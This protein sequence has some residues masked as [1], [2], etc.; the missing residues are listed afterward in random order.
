MPIFKIQILEHISRDLVFAVENPIKNVV[1]H[2][3]HDRLERRLGSLVVGFSDPGL[4]AVARLLGVAQ[5]H[6]RVGL[7]ENRVV[8]GGIAH[9]QGALHHDHLQG[10]GRG[11]TRYWNWVT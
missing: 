8:H 11:W 9:A 7:V 2:E 1:L 3:V 6:G 10:A 5:Q 4:E